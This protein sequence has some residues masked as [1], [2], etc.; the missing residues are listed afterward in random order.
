MKAT[1]TTRK[2]VAKKAAPKK[3]AAKRTTAKSSTIKVGRFGSAPES[4]N[5]KGKATVAV[6]LVKA[7]I[8]LE[9]NEKIW[10]NGTRASKSTVVK[11]GDIVSVISPKEAGLN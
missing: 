10:V 1:R 4:I 7:D 3:A 9:S 11:T 6:V 2:V 8:Q 5:V